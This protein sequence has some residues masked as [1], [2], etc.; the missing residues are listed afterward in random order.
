MY[1][2]FVM[3]YCRHSLDILMLCIWYQY[4]GNIWCSEKW[5][6]K[7]RS[8]A[9]LPA[10]HTIRCPNFTAAACIFVGG[11]RFASDRYAPAYSCA[12]FGG[13]CCTGGKNRTL[14]YGFGDHHST[15]KLHLCSCLQAPFQ[16]LAHN[17][18]LADIKACASLKG[19]FCSPTGNRTRIYGLGNRR[20]IHWTIKPFGLA[21]LGGTAVMTFSTRKRIKETVIL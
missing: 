6:F 18:R 10:T 9:K 11:L 13:L 15:I 4:I 2:A 5:R 8:T 14:T 3:T 16:G 12:H 1:R 19:N 20:S 17:A 7:N 21:R